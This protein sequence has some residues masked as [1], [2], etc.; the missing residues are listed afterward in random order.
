MTAPGKKL[1][2]IRAC[3]LLLAPVSGYLLSKASLIGRTGINLFY[4][5]YK[6]LK[7]AWKGA[8]LV[9][10]TLSVL[11]LVHRAIQN[12][13]GNKTR[14]ALH[15]VLALLGLVGLVLTY[16]DFQN[17]LSHRLLGEKFHLG[18]Y[19]FWVAWL[20]ISFTFVFEGKKQRP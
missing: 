1:T 7:T 18:A 6:F 4:K 15:L 13:S 3:A 11:W 8:L 14:V 20:I 2:L 10:I 9:F 5:E 16:Q 17:S 12:R 19:L